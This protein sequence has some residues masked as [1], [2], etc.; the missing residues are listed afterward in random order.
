M[1]KSLLSHQSSDF[2]GVHFSERKEGGE[3]GVISQA[4]WKDK[5]RPKIGNS[6]KATAPILINQTENNKAQP[7]LVSVDHIKMAD[8]GGSGPLRPSSE[9]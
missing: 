2:Y 4:V 3:T 5:H 1:P 8:L 6:L 7:L 9:P